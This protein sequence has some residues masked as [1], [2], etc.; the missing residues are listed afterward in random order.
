[1]SRAGTNEGLVSSQPHAASN[2]H[3]DA[4]CWKRTPSRSASNRTNNPGINNSRPSRTENGKETIAVKI[5][6]TA[7]NP[8]T[9]RS[10]VSRLRVKY[11]FIIC[12]HFAEIAPA[13]FFFGT[14]IFSPHSAAQTNDPPECRQGPRNRRGP[15]RGF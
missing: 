14:Q 5:K 10:L 15:S 7:M 1:A 2:F 8:R 13:T 11:L 9:S 4:T 3:S 6:T 12:E